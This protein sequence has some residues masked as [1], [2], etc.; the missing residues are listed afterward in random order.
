MPANNPCIDCGACCAYFRVTF[1]WLEADPDTQ[2]FV[3][4][5]FT[6]D[7][8]PY[9]LC[10]KGTNQ[11]KPRCAALVGEVGA[12]VTCS[13]YANRPSPCRD[14]GIQIIDGVAFATRED[15]ERCNHARAVWNLPALA[16]D[17]SLHWI[18]GR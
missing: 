8:P 5:E 11:L 7:Y 2:D 14:F 4:L 13:I 6:E 12:A 17:D 3:P 1:Y 10:M 15:T 9:R 16:F 18:T